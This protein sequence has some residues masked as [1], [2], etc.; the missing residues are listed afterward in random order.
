MIARTNTPSL[1][2]LTRNAQRQF[3]NLGKFTDTSL[4][5][6]TLDDIRGILE[7]LP[8]STSEFDLAKKR[9]GNAKRYLRS[10]ERGAARYEIRLLFGSLRN[11]LAV[12]LE[13][14]PEAKSTQSPNS[15][16]SSQGSRSDNL[17]HAP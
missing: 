11:E 17:Q 16:S 14:K 5:L 6:Q 12:E 1:Q 8:L 3:K 2:E 10:H 7:C 9:I 13:P 15:A 4:M